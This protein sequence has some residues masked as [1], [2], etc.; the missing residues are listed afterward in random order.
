MR[1]LGVIRPTFLACLSALLLLQLAWSTALP[2][3][4]G[5]D[6]IEHVL[7]VSGV[8]LGEILPADLPPRDAGLLRADGT[9]VLRTTE[10]CTM[11]RKDLDPSVCFA[12]DQHPDGTVDVPSA[13]T[14]YLPVYY[15][16]VA[17][18]SMIKGDVSIW[19]LR[20]LSAL[21]SALVLSGAWWLTTRGR[22]SLWGAAAMA[23]AM[24]PAV[25][26]AS[27]VVAPNGLHYASA[28]L[29]WAGLM[30]L[31]RTEGACLPAMVGAGVGGVLLATT[32]S[33]GPVWLGL[34]LGTWVV[35]VGRREAYALLA[36]QR[37]A[38]FVAGTA[39]VMSA[40]STA[41]WVTVY[42]TN[43]PG[44]AEPL[45]AETKAIGMAAHA[46]LWVFQT[47]GVMPYRFGVLWPEV[48]PL[49]LLPLLALVALAWMSAGGRARAALGLAIAAS[50][51]VPTVAT[52]LTYDTMGVAWQGRYG[53]PL[54]FGIV[55]M[56]G[57]VLD[58]RSV[59]LG[60]RRFSLGLTLLATTQYLF[61][62]CLGSREARGAYADGRPWPLLLWVGA[63]ILVAGGY[64]LLARTQIHALQR[65]P[66]RSDQS[67]PS[68]NAASRS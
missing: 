20:A 48:Y 28:L 34:V 46:I 18:P 54:L 60:T 68:E 45:V 61:L 15:L 41:T 8:G 16:T 36:R 42:A 21:W 29:L 33:T 66:I 32:H 14:R 38:A 27:T 17:L 9:L 7:R 59:S 4:R 3:L 12:R 52:V 50:V 51:A 56:S 64:A 1:P 24:T 55:L 10:V 39:M 6:E 67:S 62:L 57:E 25:L 37:R 11:L 49:W 63:P 13:A 43:A 40:V 35:F 26:F 53:L 22:R 31:R 5:P 30:A 23:V 2:L 58:D 19:A 47:V 65:E 44:D